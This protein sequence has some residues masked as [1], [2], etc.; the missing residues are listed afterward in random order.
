MLIIS[1]YSYNCI[2]FSNDQKLVAVGTQDSYIRVWSMDGS[3]LPSLTDRGEVKKPTNNRMLIGHSAPVMSISISDSVTLPEYRDNKEIY[4][5]PRLLL[6]SSADG[7]IRLWNLDTWRCM[8]I[9]KGHAGPAWQVQWSPHGHYFAT[10][11]RDK[12]LRIWAQDRVTSLRECVGH[13]DSISAITWHPNGL[14]VFSVSDMT[15]KSI[16]MWSIA[17]GECVR[18]MTGHTE[19]VGALECAPN[20]KILASADWGGNI[21]FW[22]LE[23]GTLIK[24]SRGHAKTGILSLSFSVDSNVLVSGS[25]D[26]T[27]RVWD[28]ELPADGTKTAVANG[29]IG[30]AFQGN[31]DIAGDTIMVG[32]QPQQPAAAPAV[33]ASAAAGASANTGASASASNKKKGKESHIT[34]DQIS[35]FPTKKTPLK[36]VKFTRMN[37]VIAAGCFDPNN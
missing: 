3:H 1:S 13:D 29:S 10:A 11:G 37:L 5:P 25:L 22:D 20:G 21:L 23:N 33:T 8:V 24:K 7:Q 15:D 34:A 35:A 9:F 16:R 32:G 18:V 14:Y 30:Q 28:V 12:V 17:T 6:S 26:G 4:Q 2:E 36:K 31:V 27:V 19:D